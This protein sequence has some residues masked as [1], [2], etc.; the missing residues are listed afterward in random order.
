MGMVGN[1][2]NNGTAVTFLFLTPS[3]S[4]SRKRGQENLNKW[5]NGNEQ[6]D[7]QIDYIEVS[8]EYRDW[9]AGALTKRVANPDIPL[10]R[11]T[12]Q[13]DEKYDAIRSQIRRY[14]NY[15]KPAHQTTI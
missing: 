7:R 5:T 13:I 4:S 12:I 11:K 8:T 2:P 14:R 1:S 9:V 3:S 15:Y 6:S 10:Q